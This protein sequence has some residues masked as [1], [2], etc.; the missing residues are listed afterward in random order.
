VRHFGGEKDLVDWIDMADDT[1][2]MGGGVDFTLDQG[3]TLSGDEDSCQR[4]RAGGSSVCTGSC[5]TVCRGGVTVDGVNV[6]V[7]GVEGD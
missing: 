2:R 3:V 5:F 7:C 4:K 1:E 6:C